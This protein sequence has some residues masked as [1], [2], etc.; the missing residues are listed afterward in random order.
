MRE[1]RERDPQSTALAVF[2][3]GCDVHLAGSKDGLIRLPRQQHNTE[4]QS[5]DKD[6]GQ[7]RKNRNLRVRQNDGDHHQQN[8]DCQFD[9]L[10]DVVLQ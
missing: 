10:S 6:Q 4:E 9:P 8:S 5:T 7:E 3:G 2:S 1:V